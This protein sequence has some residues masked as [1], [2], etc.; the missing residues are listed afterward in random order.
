MID[1][2]VKRVV[3]VFK[4]V[5]DEYFEDF[6]IIYSNEEE[7]N[8]LFY[9]TLKERLNKWK[10]SRKCIYT[11]C[12]NR[13]VRRSHTIS[14]SN[15]LRI[16]CEKGKLLTPFFDN[17]EGVLGV[18]EVGISEA[19]TFPG[20]C[21]E[22]EQLFSNYEKSGELKVSKD[23]QLQL[24]RTIC[25]EIL[26]KEIYIEHFEKTLAGYIK[27]RDMKLIMMMKDRLGKEFVGKNPKLF[28]SMEFKKLETGIE[29][30]ISDKIINFKTDLNELR[31]NFLFGIERDLEEGDMKNVYG[32]AVSLD[33][34]IP[35]ALAGRG[36]F[37]IND[38]KNSDVS[39]ILNVYPYN[40]GTYFMIAS[41]SQYKDALDKYIDYYK[42][43]I[44][45]LIN[46][47]ENWMV[48]GSDHWFIKPSIWKQ[49]RDDIKEK[50]LM[51]IS[52]TTKNIGF[53]FEYSIFNGLRK[54]FFEMMKDE[55]IPEKARQFHDVEK[56]K[57]LNSNL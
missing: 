49:L 40:G 23:F 52:D 26:V 32:I 25:R 8:T 34:C 6:T 56:M 31:N 27:F 17:Q 4:E 22:H 2:N 13:S 46:M 18:R 35:V 53:P 30:M 19:S 33:L 9:K 15:S 29:K 21:D 5:T 28:S 16:I 37:V 48:H 45:L 42:Q 50:I 1:K 10:T 20:F 24:Y 11:G 55:K 41:L 38:G 57:I 3:D 39:V 7:K 43:H 51:E 36:N 14:K 44:F 47:I 54:H 12:K